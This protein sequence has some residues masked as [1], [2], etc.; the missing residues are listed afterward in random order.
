MQLAIARAD[1]AL[2]FAVLVGMPIAPQFA[3]DRWIHI[4]TSLVLENQS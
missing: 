3:L 4:A 2:D 1:V